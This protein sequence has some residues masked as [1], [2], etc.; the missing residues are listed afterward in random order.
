MDIQALVFPQ[1]NDVLV[2]ARF[3]DIAD[4]TGITAEL[5]DKPDRTTP[6]DDPAVLVYSAG[7]EADPD[8]SGQTKAVFAVPAT[9]TQDPRMDWWRVDAVD[10]NNKRRTAASGPLWVEAV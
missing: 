1:G 10:V 7:L 2:T 3:P 5:Y 4:G 9:D 8:Y 6:N